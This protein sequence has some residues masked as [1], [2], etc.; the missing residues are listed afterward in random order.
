MVSLQ[1]TIALLTAGIGLFAGTISL[2]TGLHKDGEKTDLIFG[3]LCIAIFI[4]FLAP[5]VG[6][7]ILDKAPYSTEVIFKRIFNFIFFGIFPW[8]VYFYTGYKKRTLPISIGS[9]NLVCYFLMMFSVKD[10]HAPLWIFIALIVIGMSI[11]HGFIAVGYQF[12][13]GVRTSA[14]W[15]QAAMFVYLFLFVTSTIYQTNIDFFIR[16]LHTK[17]FFPINLFPL[18]FILIMGVRLRAHTIEKFQLERMLRFKNMEWESLMEKMQLVVVRTDK[19]GKMGYINPYGVKLLHY[20][21]PSELIGKNWQ[22]YFLPGP[23]AD[24][25]KH[26]FMKAI[27]HKQVMPSYNNIVVARDGEEKSVTWTTELA[28]DKD[29]SVAGLVHFGLNTTDQD[30]AYKQIQLLKSELEK[31]NLMLKGEALPAWMQEEIIGKSEAILYAI[32]KAKKVSV[33]QAAVLLEGE[34]GVGKELFAELI[35]RSSL[36]SMKPFVKVNCGALPAELIEDELFGHEKGA[37]TGAVN[38]RKGRF[39]IADGGTIFL[40]EIGELP[41]SLQPK[42]LRVLQNGEFERVGGQQTIKVDVR[43]IAAT[44]RELGAE[45]LAGRFRDDLFYRLNVFPI[46]IPALRDRKEDIPMLIQFFI[47]KESK[48]HGKTFK[49]I[50]KSDI[51]NLSQYNWPGNIREMRNVIERAVIN[52]DSDTIRFDLF[53]QISAQKSKPNYSDSLEELEKEH[54]LK[55]LMETN[56]RVSGEGGAAEKLDMNPST[57]RS[58]IKKLNI[59]KVSGKEHH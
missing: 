6:F 52:S 31:E 40:D 26:V 16:I 49:N 35:Q 43:V 59:Y 9:L 23:D 38:S 8:F 2:F 18:S 10:N 46:T 20:N 27:T 42:L 25:A 53:Y 4:Y 47:D 58:R 56:W 45:V 5:P 22:E 1:L 12:K 32:H 36:R 11:V 7:I 24:Y 39:E 21:Q 48:K 33:T 28:Y 3:I 41:I 19:N 51:N 44:N 54:I 29:G 17:I 14:K 50:N 37:F 55:V 15:F 13:T 57:L 30:L 34:T